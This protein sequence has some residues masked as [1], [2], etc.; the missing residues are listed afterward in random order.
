[1]VVELECARPTL[2]AVVAARR[3]LGA[4]LLAGAVPGG[5][6]PLL[7]LLLWLLLRLAATAT[8]RD[9]VLVAVLHLCSL[10]F[11][12]RRRARGREDSAQVV[13]IDASQE[14]E[15]EQTERC[16]KPRA[17]LAQQGD[18]VEET[19]CVPRKKTW[20]EDTSVHEATTQSARTRM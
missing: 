17:H 14:E 15:P 2:A 13:E 20:K 3:L 5:L 19:A 9:G 7:L 1:V 6:C 11:M 12:S 4:A 8:R 16:M 10:L 18:G